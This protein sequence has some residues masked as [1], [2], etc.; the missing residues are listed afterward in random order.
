MIQVDVAPELRTVL[1]DL[2][3]ARREG[4]GHLRGVDVQDGENQMI[5]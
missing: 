4:L 5:N 1:Q 3:E 2:Q